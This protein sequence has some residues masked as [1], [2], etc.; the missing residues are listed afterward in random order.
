MLLALQAM[1]YC[2][3]KAWRLAQ[4][5]NPESA[6]NNQIASCEKLAETAWKISQSEIT[7]AKIL[8]RKI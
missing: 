1:L 4:E 2:P 7:A 8:F 3:H 6:Q 5:N